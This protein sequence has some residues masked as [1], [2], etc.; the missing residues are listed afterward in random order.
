MC[1]SGFYGSTSS[2]SQQE[3]EPLPITSFACQW[4][5]PCKRK[6]STMQMSEATFQKH[7][8]GHERKRQHKSLEDFDPRPPEYKKTGESRLT[9]LL[10]KVRGK[11]LCVSLL[12]DTTYQ[13]SESTSNISKP[14]ELPT[15]QELQ[16]N[17]SEFKK[18]LELPE[19]EMRHIEQSTRDQS[20][21]PLWY[22]VRRYRLTAS[23]FGEVCHR[24]PTTS[25]H[26]LVLR[27]LGAKQFQSAATEWGRRNEEL[28][29]KQYQQQQYD[30]G[31][32]SFYYCQS[33]FVICKEY[34]FLGASPDAVVYDPTFRDSF[35]LAEV[36][37]PY[38]SKHLTPSQACEKKDF[39]SELKEVDGN[40][41][42]QLKRNHKYFFQIQGQMA[43]T[44]RSWCDFII[45]TE[46]GL[47]VERILFDDELWKTEMLPK[48]IDFFD[49]C[50]A[51]E[52]VSPV[53]VLGMA[54][55]DLRKM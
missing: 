33:G 19:I 12:F 27:I 15:K 34:P 51:P 14:P 23:Y 9:N 55:R 53:H 6:Q 25:P 42:V 32:E 17:V 50:L 7:V 45:Y 20:Q 26:S 24:L 40:Q 48:L 35:G 18:S 28:A 3:G 36:K 29:L 37:C 31:N 2:T 46:K 39:C 21:S 49:N 44:G 5:P 52:I 47:A 1:S 54:V 30:L 4:R 13:T 16:K 11:G 43:V 10:E 38:S 41:L 22:T 8:Y